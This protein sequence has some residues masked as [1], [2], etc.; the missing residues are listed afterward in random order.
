MAQLVNLMRDFPQCSSLSFLSLRALDYFDPIRELPMIHR[1]FKH[2][3][4]MKLRELTLDEDHGEWI[5]WDPEDRLYE[6]LMPF[7]DNLLSLEL[8]QFHTL[9]TRSHVFIATHCTRLTSLSINNHESPIECDV[10]NQI[11]IELSTLVT[12]QLQDITMEEGYSFFEGLKEALPDSDSSDNER[13]LLPNLRHLTLG[14]FRIFND[15]DYTLDFI[16][17]VASSLLSLTLVD[18]LT[19]SNLN[20]A[21]SRCTHLT[22]LG[23]ELMDETVSHSFLS[24]IPSSI[25]SISLTSVEFGVEDEDEDED[26]DEAGDNSGDDNMELHNHMPSFPRL[27]T[28]ELRVSGVTDHHVRQLLSSSSSPSSL[29]SLTF[30]PSPPSSVSSPLFN[31]LI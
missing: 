15:E 12:L 7:A 25:E 5:N 23:V 28:I 27:H 29:T 2:I 14:Q 26:E 13:V 9:T 30:I 31:S 24:F 10:V 1:H 17:M 19:F 16:T 20:K 4:H 3:R 18:S 6:F 22:K 21:V 8:E 11:L